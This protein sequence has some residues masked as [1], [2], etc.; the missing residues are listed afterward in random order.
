MNSPLFSK[1]G[2]A[3][4]YYLWKFTSM[5]ESLTTLQL[6]QYLWAVVWFVWACLVF[7]MFVQWWQILS[8][9][10]SRNEEEKNI[11]LDNASKRYEITFTALVIFGWAMFA[12]FPMFYS[13]S[14]GWAYFVWF[15]L[16]FLF[17]IEWVSFKYRTKVSNFLWAKT[18]EILL[19]LNGLFTPLLLWVVVSTFFTWVNFTVNKVNMLNLWEWSKSIT[20]WDNIFHG[21][22]A[23][24]NPVQAAF[25]SNISLWLALV[26]LA[27]LMALLNL[28]KNL[29][30][31]PNSLSPLL[32]SPQGRGK[33]QN[34]ENFPFINRIKRVFPWASG[35][36]LFFFLFYVIRLLFLDWFAY[37]P[38]TKEVFIESYKYLNNFIQMPLL[39]WLFILWVLLVLA[40]ILIFQFKRYNRSFW[41]VWVWVI[42]VVESLFLLAW[43]NSTSFYPSLSDL[44]SSLTIENASSSRYTLVV[45]S[46]STLFMPVVLSYIIWVWKQITGIKIEH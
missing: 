25:L 32:T 37:N 29:Q 39:A 14:F 6:Q 15:T 41:I 10:L 45:I 8:L 27:I 23:L 35:L 7:L 26:F 40:W 9:L 43:F 31:H 16:L 34:I 36:F 2:E 42:F 1:R 21:Y 11:I 3:A 38:E 30:L 22:E 17:I 46:Y 18:Y 13:T 20:S 24:W 4:L 44:Q 5:F 28:Y 33:E 19:F 12:V